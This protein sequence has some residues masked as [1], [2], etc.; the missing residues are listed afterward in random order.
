MSD[1]IDEALK[2]A[3][4]AEASRG[5]S[6]QV[7]ARITAGDVDHG[8]WWP[9]VAATCAVLALVVALGWVM[10]STTHDGSDQ[11]S[12]S[13]A[14][15]IAGL[16]RT[17]APQLELRARRQDASASTPV[18]KVTRPVARV[19]AARSTTDDHDRA[20]APLSPLD[21]LSMR[22]IDPDAMV[23]GDQVVIPLAPI[24]PIPVVG[25]TVGDNK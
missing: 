9:R 19:R 7:R 25:E 11:L 12:T 21:G 20:L 4:H 8:G 15:E 23:L 6:A 2:A 18:V 5:F 13:A 1:P 10:R 17:A 3:A 24:A 22:P 16:P 14:G